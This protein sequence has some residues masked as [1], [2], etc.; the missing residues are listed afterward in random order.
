LLDKGVIVERGTH[1]SLLAAGGLY[2]S[3]WNRQRIAEQARETLARV[4][5]DDAAPNRVPPPLGQTPGIVTPE[6]AAADAAE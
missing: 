4:G 6:I 2:A 1:Q 5:D 3:M